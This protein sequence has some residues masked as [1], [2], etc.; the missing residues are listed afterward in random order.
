V[1]AECARLLAEASGAD[2]MCAGQQLDMDWEGGSLT[3]AQLDQISSRKTGALIEA[4]CVMGCVAGGGT[5][6]QKSAAAAYARNI[7]LAFQIRDDMLDVLS[8][9]EEL[10]K[11][12]GSDVTE[13]KTTYMSL[14]GREKCEALIKRLTTEAIRVLKE[15]FIDPD[16]LCQF[17]AS[18]A[19]RRN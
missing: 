4:A 3:E 11:P 15:A 1:R 2:G 10:G 14:L 17:A 9:D 18:L 13:G 6:K 16:F 12:V 19:E 7:G 8:T 5:E